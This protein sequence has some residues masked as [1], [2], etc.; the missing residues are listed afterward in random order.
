[1]NRA[2][3]NMLMPYID[4]LVGLFLHLSPQRVGRVHSSH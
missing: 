4:E 1:L 2:D 3:L